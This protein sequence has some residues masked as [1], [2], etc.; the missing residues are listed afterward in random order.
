MD[1]KTNG[2]LDYSSEDATQLNESNLLN[3]ICTQTNGNNITQNG[4][5][6]E[7]TESD[8][9]KLSIR[10]Q[11]EEALHLPTHLKGSESMEPDVY[12]SYELEKKGLV[13]TDISHKSVKPRFNFQKLEKVHRE[14]FDG[15]NLDFKVWRCVSNVQNA[16]KD[17]LIGVAKV[18]VSALFYGKCDL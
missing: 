11:I 13:F 10:F 15:K 7:V 3:D 14:V 16:E 9:G 17:I 18:D 4:G 2:S 12:V 5:L 6:Q 1:T 8:D